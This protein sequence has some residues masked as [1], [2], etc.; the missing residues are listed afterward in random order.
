V[1]IDYG[2]FEDIFAEIGLDETA[3]AVMARVVYELL[4]E[5]RFQLDTRD[6]Q[7]LSWLG[8]ALPKIAEKAL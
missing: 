2:A 1:K 7:V 3:A 6:Y 4:E 5:V 8:L